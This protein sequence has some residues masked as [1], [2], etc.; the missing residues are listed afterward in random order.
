[1]ELN[2]GSNIVRNSS[3]ILDVGGKEQISLGI[4]KRD[5]QLLLSADFYDSDGNHI[6]KLKRNAW[7]FNQ[8]ERY[9]I[10]T[11]PKS[12]KLIEKQTGQTVF[13]ATVAGKDKIEI[14]WG[15]F[16][17]HEGHLL[18]ITPEF[19]R[20]GGVTMSGNI[21]DSTGGAVKIG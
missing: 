7:V 4:G 12:L 13:E 9:E 11:H 14:P 15:K 1:M 20:I 19:W 5:K 3:G 2:I 6:A 10:T 21:I 17:T 18:E 8:E 16:F